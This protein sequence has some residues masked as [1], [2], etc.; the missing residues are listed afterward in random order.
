MIASTLYEICVDKSKVS[1]DMFINFLSNS[2]IFFIYFPDC[3]RISSINEKEL[4][5][6]GSTKTEINRKCDYRSKNRKKYAQ[7]MQ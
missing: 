4:I 1:L 5:K 2:C 3:T 6:M 7:S